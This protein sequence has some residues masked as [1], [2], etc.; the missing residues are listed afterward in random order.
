MSNELLD[1]GV[2]EAAQA[3]ATGKCSSVELTKAFLG[4]IKAQE[5]QIQAFLSLSEELALQ[6][7]NAAD[8]KFFEL[9]KHGEQPA[10]PLLGIPFAIKDVLTVQGMACTGEQITG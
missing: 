1:L 10:S 3:L 9:R 7:A 8:K 4:Q 5:P 2:V 6:Q